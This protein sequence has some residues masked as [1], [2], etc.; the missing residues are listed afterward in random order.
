VSADEFLQGA[1]E[2][3]RQEPGLALLIAAGLHLFLFILTVVVLI[4]QVTIGRRQARLLRGADGQSLEK[5]LLDHADGTQEVRSQL[6]RAEET[7][8]S[9]ARSLR[10]CLQ[11]VG[12]LRYNAF[13]DVGGEQSF[14]VALL[15][16]DSNGLVM[17]GLYSR[18]DMRIY[19]KPI[20]DGQS[21]VSLSTEEQEAITSAQT[22][23]AKSAET[24]AKSGE[25]SRRPRPAVGNGT[26]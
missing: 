13:N 26:A 4:R 25:R 6:A 10:G 11:R 23:G 17:T 24:S 5:M 8:V 14:S 22:G 16:G 2:W 15:D 18:N 21:P 3:V 1:V 7:G 12:I 20:V 19:A 9:H